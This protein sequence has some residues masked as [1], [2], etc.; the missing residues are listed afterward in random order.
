MAKRVL[1]APMDWGLGHATRCV[2]IV[3]ELLLQGHDVILGTTPVTKKILVTEFPNIEQVELVPY[4][5]KYS[6]YLP[7]WWNILI[8]FPR[9]DRIVRQEINRTAIIVREK[10]IDTIISDNRYGCYSSATKNILLTH[11]LKIKSPVFEKKGNELLKKKLKH[12]DEIWV[13][14]NEDVNHNLSG[15]L[16]HGNF[17][18]PPIKYIGNLSRFNFL[19]S[20]NKKEFAFSFLIS[21]IEPKRTQF[22]NEA[23]DFI[24]SSSETCSLIRGTEKP[25]EK[26]ITN[27]K[28]E[29]FDFPSTFTIENILNTSGFVVCRSGYSSIMDLAKLRIPAFLLPTPGQTEQ[30]YLA[31]YLDGKFGFRKITSVNDIKKLLE[32]KEV[33]IKGFVNQQKLNESIGSLL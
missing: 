24:N 18:H 17:N 22:E 13:P 5:I 16:S 28:C 31:D 6:K 4:K 10:K 1:V 14:D 20:E 25:L 27:Y 32:I 23:I 19:A 26:K 11:Q 7:V 30:E 9:L 12:F 15:E 3:H 2:T 33:N 8:D 21:G 29:I